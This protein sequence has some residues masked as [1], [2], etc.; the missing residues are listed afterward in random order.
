MDLKLLAAL[1]DYIDAAIE[2]RAV[3]NSCGPHVSEARNART[4]ARQKLLVAA[5]RLR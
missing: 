1:V 4:A 5:Q 2:A 3:Q